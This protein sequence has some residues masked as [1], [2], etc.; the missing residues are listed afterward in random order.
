MSQFLRSFIQRL[1]GKHDEFEATD[2]DERLGTTRE[3]KQAATLH[4]AS[5]GKCKVG[6]LPPSD[7]EL[8]VQAKAQAFVIKHGSITLK[9]I[10][11]MGC[12]QPA[13][14][15]HRLRKL[16][17]VKPMEFDKWEQGKSGRFKRYFVTSQAKR[18]AA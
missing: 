6:F 1:T 13:K 15:L 9:D 18:R 16:G 10:V 7:N 12:N 8:K 2:F 11:N 3:D 17:V 14:L 5:E 4:P